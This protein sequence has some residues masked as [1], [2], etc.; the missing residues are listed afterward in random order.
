MFTV[1]QATSLLG[2]APRTVQKWCKDL[3]FEKV[4]R[5]YILTDKQISQIKIAC[6]DGPGRPKLAASE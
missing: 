5:D 1:T 2:I 3:G 6:H 4:G